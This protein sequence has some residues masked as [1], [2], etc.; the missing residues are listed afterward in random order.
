M[1]SEGFPRTVASAN[2]CAV[3]RSFVQNLDI[4]FGA[5]LLGAAAWFVADFPILRLWLAT[6]FA[7][8]AVCLWRW[9]RLWLFALPAL[10]PTFDL[11][12]WSGRFFFN[13]FDAFVLL[14]AGILIL[15]DRNSHQPE[16]VRPALNG[17]LL[18]L[19]VSY[20]V[21]VAIRLWPFP[22]V[23]P[24]SF[25]DYYSPFNGL[26]MAKGFVWALLLYRPLKRALVEEPKARV[27]LCS[28]FVAGLAG[29]SAAAI[30]ERWMFPGLLT[31]DTD[32]RISATFSGMHTGDGP[33]DVLVGH[34]YAD[35][36]GFSAVP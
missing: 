5:V 28:G 4:L 33:I 14:T 18:L 24:D 10:L 17:I 15:R 8:Y 35:A 27:I 13:E 9:P 32:Y 2:G 1:G 16:G 22:P 12:P 11:A 25:A 6:G 36:R 29:V 31:L 20:A 23:T 30:V 21:G 3:R 34:I 19:A 7:L 26:R